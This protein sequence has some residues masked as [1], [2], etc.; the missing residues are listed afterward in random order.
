MPFSVIILNTLCC[1]LNLFFHSFLVLYASC[2]R[3]LWPLL[4]QLKWLYI[5]QRRKKTIRFKSLQS[6]PFTSNIVR[7]LVIFLSSYLRKGNVLS[8]QCWPFYL[9]SLSYLLLLF[10][11]SCSFILPK[12]PSVCTFPLTGMF[13]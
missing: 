12:Q 3:Y 10:F 1:N 4:Y 6:L 9:F 5:L 8:F 13:L 7:P 11:I 2:S